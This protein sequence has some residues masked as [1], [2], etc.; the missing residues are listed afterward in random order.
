MFVCTFFQATF[1]SYY[2]EKIMGYK[3]IN[4][5]ETEH[6]N[7]IQLSAEVPD[8]AVYVSTTIVCSH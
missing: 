4:K 8:G 6:D 2:N 1:I 7:V 3:Y 5:F